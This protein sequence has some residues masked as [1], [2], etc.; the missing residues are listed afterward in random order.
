MCKKL[1]LRKALTCN[2]LTLFYLWGGG[3]V[4][5][6]GVENA[7]PFSFFKISPKLHKTT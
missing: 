3:G 2:I 7:L 1:R 5:V 4:G 6:G